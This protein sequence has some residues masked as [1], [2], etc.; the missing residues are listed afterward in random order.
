MEP[1]Q[2]FR[3]SFHGFNREDVV[4]YIEYVNARHASQIN[5]LKSEIQNLQQELQALRAEPKEDSR[6]AQL[7]ESCQMLTRERDEA[8]AKLARVPAVPAAAPSPV[9]EELEAYRRAE[10]TER[11]ARERV[12]QMYHQASGILADATVRV[13]EAAAQIESMTN[14]VAAQL[15]QL[16]SAVTGSKSALKDAVASMYALRPEGEE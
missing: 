16:R 4:R 7:E 6:V 5:Q 14:E 15:D 9:S 11:M 12:S 3:T 13:D 1:L 8:L 2:N 10:R